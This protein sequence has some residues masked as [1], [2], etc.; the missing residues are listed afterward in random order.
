MNKY[1]YWT[2][3]ILGILFI[4]FISM[5]SLD[6]GSFLG[7]IMHMIPSF[8]LIIILIIA[9][10]WEKI[11]G[12]IFILISI[13]MTLFFRTYNDILSLM[14]I[15][16]IPFLIG[17]LFLWKSIGKYIKDIKIRLNK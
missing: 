3:R 7:W 13:V 14:T 17:L 4:M 11:G 12:T 2:P 9:W 15:S 10:K 5:F 6:A 16:G 8:V 1:L